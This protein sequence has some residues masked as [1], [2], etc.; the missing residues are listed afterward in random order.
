MKW[1]MAVE[2]PLLKPLERDGALPAQSRYPEFPSVFEPAALYLA[3]ALT[4]KQKQRE[5]VAPELVIKRLAELGWLRATSIRPGCIQGV[6]WLDFST[7]R[8]LG[9]SGIACFDK[10]GNGSTRRSDV[11][12][13]AEK[14][15]AHQLPD[16]SQPRCSA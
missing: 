9:I 1:K 15:F 16:S 3:V 13:F 7:A 11:G 5:L 6:G 14:V 2:N 8:F 10:P 12:S 4:G